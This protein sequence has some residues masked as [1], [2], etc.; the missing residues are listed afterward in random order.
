M[1][2]AGKINAYT[3][4]KCQKHTITVNR[5]AGT[6]PF[7]IGCKQPGSCNGTASSRFY[8]CSQEL[9]P[10]WEFYKPTPEQVAALDPD[11]PDTPW[12]I[13]HARRG[14]LFFRPIKPEVKK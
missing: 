9:K 12:L 4:E 3:C 11:E 5:D 1:E 2:E 8:R 13:D 6:T 7:L 14:G 10:T